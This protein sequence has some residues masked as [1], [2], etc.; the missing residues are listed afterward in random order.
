RLAAKGTIFYNT[1]K[2]ENKDEYTLEVREFDMEDFKKNPNIY[3]IGKRGSGKSLIIKNIIDH[4]GPKI[5]PNTIIISPTEKINNFYR[6]LYKDAKIMYKYKKSTIRK[7]IEGTEE[8][9]LLIL[10]DCMVKSMITD[11]L[12]IEIMRNSRHYNMT[13]ILASQYSLQLSP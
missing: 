6:P 1:R 3:I 2:H 5:L 8:E 13:V 11:N 9:K 4:Y 12:F 10:D 7:F